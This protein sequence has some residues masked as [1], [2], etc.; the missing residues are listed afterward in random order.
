MWT[1]VRESFI[2]TLSETVNID[3]INKYKVFVK[4]LICSIIK[5]KNK[6]N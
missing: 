1:R 2:M 4:T 5:Y 3:F 6:Q